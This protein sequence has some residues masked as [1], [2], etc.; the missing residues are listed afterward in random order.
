MPFLPDELDALVD[1]LDKPL[2]PRAGRKDVR[3]AADLHKLLL[4]LR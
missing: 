4:V 1:L 3:D 2:Q